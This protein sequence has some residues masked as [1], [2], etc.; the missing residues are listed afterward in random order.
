MNRNSGAGP[1]RV[2]VAIKGIRRPW[3]EHAYEDELRRYVGSVG[4]EER[5]MIIKKSAA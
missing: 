2:T 3:K 5:K 4:G 1:E